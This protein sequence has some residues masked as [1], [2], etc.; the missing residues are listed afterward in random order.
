MAIYMQYKGVDGDVEETGHAK[1]IELQSFEVQMQRRIR[2]RIGSSAER[3]SSAP[4][5]SEVVVTKKN[6][7]A[8][9]KLLQEALAGLG[10]DVTIDF[11]RTNKGAEEVFLELKLSDVMISNFAHAT[12]GDG[13]PTEQLS[14]NYTKVAWSTKQMKDDGKPGQPFTVT[15]DLAKAMTS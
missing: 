8:T 4:T 6:D 5:V 10:K 15:Y 1:W 3:E 11:T 7:V 14:L 12:G 2:G 13:R 9:G